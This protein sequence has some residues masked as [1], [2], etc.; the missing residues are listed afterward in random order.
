MKTLSLKDFKGNKDAYYNFK[1]SY[2]ESV[3]KLH[4]AM[5]HSCFFTPSEVRDAAEHDG[6]N[7]KFED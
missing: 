5:R 6:M 4:E 3:E 2:Q 1:K 7:L